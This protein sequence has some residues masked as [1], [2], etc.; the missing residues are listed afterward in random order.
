MIQPFNNETFPPYPFALKSTKSLSVRIVTP[1]GIVWQ[2]PAQSVTLPSKD[3]EMGILKGHVAITAMIDVGVLCLRSDDQVLCFCIQTGFA[4]VEADEIIVLVNKAEFGN[5][6]NPEQ[7]QNSL[8]L[9]INNS[10]QALN[11]LEKIQ[12]KTALKVAKARLKAAQGVG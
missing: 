3:G 11:K 6:I 5:K 8:E 12:A 2:G 7:A 4:Q 1:R 10:H 9:A